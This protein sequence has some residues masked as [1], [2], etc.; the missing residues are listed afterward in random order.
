MDWNNF[1][2]HMTFIAFFLPRRLKWRWSDE[3]R[4]GKSEGINPFCFFLATLLKNF[5]F[6][7]MNSRDQIFW[8]LLELS[9]I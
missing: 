2:F 9:V 4:I 7:N 3:Q 6:T 1:L 5:T 8:R